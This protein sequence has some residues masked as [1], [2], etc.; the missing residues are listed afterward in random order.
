MIH[1]KN[2]YQFLWTLFFLFSVVNG[3]AR[4]ATN[5]EK[6]RVAYLTTRTVVYVYNPMSASDFGHVQRST[7]NVTSNGEPLKESRYYPHNGDTILCVGPTAKDK[8]G[9]TMVAEFGRNIGIKKGV[10]YLFT[11]TIDLEGVGPV[12]Q[13]KQLVTGT[14]LGSDAVFGIAAPTVGVPEQWIDEDDR[15]WYQI[16]IPHND[17]GGNMRGYYQISFRAYSASL[18]TNKIGETG[19]GLII[20]SGIGAAAGLAVSG[21]LVGGHIAG[22]AEDV[23]KTIRKVGVKERA[24]VEVAEQVKSGKVSFEEAIRQ[25]EEAS[26]Y[27]RGVAVDIGERSA[28]YAGVVSAV[29]LGFATVGGLITKIPSIYPNVMYKIEYIQA[30]NAQP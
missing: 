11:E 23:K 30:E 22:T 3:T 1:S 10:T 17:A 28:G 6:S 13:L 12:L 5:D 14:T 29:T 21:V 25:Q 24:S 8:S 9:V 19:A 2:R 26:K 27:K 4:A 16:V 15:N 20:G 18:G 7:F